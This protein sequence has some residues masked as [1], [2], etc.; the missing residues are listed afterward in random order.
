MYRFFYCQLSNCFFLLQSERDHKELQ[1]DIL[2][3]TNNCEVLQT[4]I[5]ILQKDL[6][7][8]KKNYLEAEKNNFELKSE[9]ERLKSEKKDL[10]SR[11]TELELSHEDLDIKYRDVEATKESLKADLESLRNCLTSKDDELISLREQ[12]E[13]ALNL[14]NE[15][16]PLGDRDYAELIDNR[17]QHALVEKIREEKNQLAAKLAEAEMQVK[18]AEAMVENAVR[19][20]DEAKIGEEK[21]KTY[22][23]EQQRETSREIENLRIEKN[24]LL[25]KL[26]ADTTFRQE[27][28]E[29]RCQLARMREQWEINEND[30]LARI[31]GLERQCN[32]ILVREKE[33]RRSLEYF[34][35]ENERMRQVVMAQA[36]GPN[37]NRAIFPP[38]PPLPMGDT[39]IQFDN[40][41]S[42]SWPPEWSA[43]DIPPPPPPP[44]ALF[45]SMMNHPVPSG[46]YSSLSR[47]N[48]S[49][50]HHGSIAGAGSTRETYSPASQRSDQRSFHDDYPYMV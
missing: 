44:P 29:L 6:E 4:K 17:S 18:T 33:L 49:S 11:L 9:L 13:H 39:S 1:K 2:E 35:F 27:N 41:A 48:Y 7:E 10:E 23:H 12:V 16:K 42:T 47:Q 31:R 36:Q 32:E 30:Q 20:R 3:K 14:V 43:T 26:G 21:M 40:S 24:E 8:H 37:A 28:E 15:Q 22:F 34:K 46:A 25:A 5:D 45:S 19:E 38:P 50:S